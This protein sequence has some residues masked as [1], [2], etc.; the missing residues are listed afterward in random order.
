M[1]ITSFFINNIY[2][3]IKRYSMYNRVRYHYLNESSHAINEGNADLIERLGDLDIYD[4]DSKGYIKMK[5]TKIIKVVADAQYK[6]QRDY[7]YFNLFLEKCKIMY[8]PTFPS[9]ITDTMAVDDY[10]NLWINCSFV[11][12]QCKM[13]TNRVFG[14]LFHELFHIFLDHC[15]RFNEKYPAEMYGGND[16]KG[17]REK[18]NMKANLCMDYEVNASMVDDGIVSADFWKRMNGLYKKEYTGKTW[19]ELMDTVGDQEYRDWL[20]RN[21]YSLDDVELKVLE[22]I[23]KAAKTLMNPDAEDE[24]KRFARKQ[25]QK[26]L[27][28]ILGK[29]DR[30]EKT[31]QDTLE[32]L[33]NTKLGDIG[34]ISQ[35]LDD[36]VYDLYKDPKGMSS[37]E[38]DKTLADMDALMDEMGEN[39]D[40]IASQFGKNSKETGDDINNARQA[41]KDAMKKINDGNTS[42]D[43]RQ[44]LLDAAKDALEDIISDDV[45]KEKLKKKREER[46]AKKAAERKERFKKRHP[47]RGLIIL[48][49]NFLDLREYNLICEKTQEVLPKII[50]ELEPLTELRFD[51]MKKSMF[52]NLS[53]YLDDLRNSFFDDLVALI[54]D[55][56]ILNKDEA[57]MNKL[58]DMAFDTLYDSLRNI[59]DKSIPEEDKASHIK[60]AIQKMRL[61][62]K[63]LKT[64]KVWRVSDEFKEAYKAEMQRL[65]EIYKSGGDEALFEELYN[66]G[67]IDIFSLDDNG[68]KLLSDLSKKMGGGPKARTSDQGLQSYTDEMSEWDGTDEEVK[69]YEGKL[70]YK[71]FNIS[72]DDVMLV[73]SDEP[74]SLRDED[75]EQFGLKFEKDFPDYWVHRTAESV[76]EVTYAGKDEFADPDELNK[77]LEDN[78]DYELGNWEWD[79]EE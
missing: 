45:A 36:V 8:I 26:T 6:I 1:E 56:T 57:Y 49:Q 7:P 71:V 59:L 77:K 79:T 21:G 62:G 55:E 27:D 64:Q 29:Q 73:L 11:Y 17:V 42:G 72:D 46:D 5:A 32:D 33:Q 61:I 51:E 50:E 15:V 44:D 31:L 10:C 23:E 25:L 20:K 34:D 4:L 41:L 63:C 12:N 9:N 54:K 48:M 28:E 37:E 74:D 75:F 47:L 18:A 30:G 2:C 52:R 78:P 67:V 3:H 65:M 13:D 22:A 76:F 14:I 53:N 70:Y 24:D 69:P 39:V 66:L 43:E 35:K 60:V 19:E 40:E 16:M 68:M 38:L 58:L